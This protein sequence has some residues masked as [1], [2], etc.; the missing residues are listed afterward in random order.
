MEN[1]FW[2]ALGTSTL[3][4]VVTSLCIYTIRRFSDWR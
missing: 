3:A 2:M 4:A 1:T